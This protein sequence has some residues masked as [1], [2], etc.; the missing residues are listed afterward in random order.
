LPL[1]SALQDGSET[2]FWE[3]LGKS[4]MFNPYKAAEYELMVT[5]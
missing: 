4:D 2:N 5:N 1:F 3:M